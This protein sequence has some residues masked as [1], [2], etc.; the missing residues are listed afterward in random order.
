MVMQVPR[1]VSSVNATSVGGSRMVL[2]TLADQISL[3]ITGLWN[4]TQTGICW[5]LRMPTLGPHG[6]D[7]RP[8]SAT[9]ELCDLEKV[10]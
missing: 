4:F 7:S 9:H 2:Q 6:L 10:T 8:V 3:R 5:C 1:Q